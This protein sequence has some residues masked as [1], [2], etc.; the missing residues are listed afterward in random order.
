MLQRLRNPLQQQLTS[1]TASDAA[2]SGPEQLELEEI[3]ELPATA[4]ELALS[5]RT[6]SRCARR[7]GRGLCLCAALLLLPLGALMAADRLEAPPAAVLSATPSQLHLA[8]GGEGVGAGSAAAAAGT[9]SMDIAWYTGLLTADSLVRYRLAASPGA[10]A[11]TATGASERYL[12]VEHG[13]HHHVLLTGLQPGATYTY[14]CGSAVAAAWSASKQFKAPPAPTAGF[15][16]ALFGDMGWEGSDQRPMKV[17]T[18]VLVL[19]LLVLLGAGASG[20]G[21]AGTAAAPA[22]PAAPLAPAACTDVFLSQLT[23]S[24]LKQEWSAT[25]TRDRLIKLLEQRK[26]DAIWHLG[27]IGYVDDAF[28]H[29][30]TIFR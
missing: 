10:A 12:S 7:A 21:A 23:V 17:R 24:G 19:V 3:S 27:D 11:K 5:A 6:Q 28:A 16:M 13:F 2:L 9:V 20:S 18:M 30:P 8:V 25:H 22:A 4:R 26:F 1:G 15:S 14:E 29:L